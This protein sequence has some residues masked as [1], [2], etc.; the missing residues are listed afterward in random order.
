M[1]V[2]SLVTRR[3]VAVTTKRPDALFQAG[4]SLAGAESLSTA[5]S[6]MLSLSLTLFTV[7]VLYCTVGSDE[8]IDW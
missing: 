2:D 3:L 8:V 6:S 5:N 4:A 7:T 1:P